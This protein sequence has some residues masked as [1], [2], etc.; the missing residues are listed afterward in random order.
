MY[1]ID[2]I[3]LFVESHSGGDDEDCPRMRTL[4]GKR[5]RAII[6]DPRNDENIIVN[7]L[8]LAFIKYHNAVARQLIEE[9]TSQALTAEE[10]AS[11]I[12]G[13]KREILF[14]E[15][16][17]L[18]RW[19]YQ[20]VVIH[21]F[22]HQLVGEAVIADIFKEEPYVAFAPKDG[23]PVQATLPKVALKFYKWKHQPFMPVEFSAAAFRF[24]HSLVRAVYRIN[25]ELEDKEVPDIVIF[26]TP[27]DDE[28][29]QRLGLKLNPLSLEGFKERPSSWEINWAR[30]F[31]LDETSPVQMARQIN[32]QLALGLSALPGEPAQPDLTALAARNL[33]RG[34]ALQLPSGQNIAQAMGLPAELI[35]TQNRMQLPQRLEPTLAEKLG[36]AAPLWYY[37]LKEAE[38]LAGGQQLGPVGGRIVAEV[39]IGLLVGDPRSYFNND[40]RWQ[41]ELRLGAAEAEGKIRFTMAELLRFA[42]ARIGE[43]A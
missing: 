42:G 23:E 16:R 33:L 1:D 14:E 10:A 41:P 18:T 36:R 26:K 5:G 43:T 19:H 4:A 11:Q 27:F 9:E 32:T 13:H 15:A 31:K 28:L 24:G 7:Q 22:L 37:I 38:V 35:L 3:R 12:P 21:D 2:G 39:L 30:F 25:K 20:W 6:G 8:H 17:R 40:P 34:E 29:A